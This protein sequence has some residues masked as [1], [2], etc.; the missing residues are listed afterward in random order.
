MCVAP[1]VGLF[2]G[3]AAG[4][5]AG[6]VAGLSS[7]C[8]SMPNTAVA[9]RLATRCDHNVTAARR[10]LPTQQQ[11]AG[12]AGT[13]APALRTVLGR[14]VRARH[15]AFLQD[16]TPSANNQVKCLTS[17]VKVTRHHSYG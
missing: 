14:A 8:V 6:L 11:R 7:R 4:L 12:T 9:S 2:V 16:A 10:P 1:A 15:G 17:A 13:I 3:L 5:V